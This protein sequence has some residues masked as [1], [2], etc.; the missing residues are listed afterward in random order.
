[1]KATKD[2]PGQWQNWYWICFAGAVLFIPATLLMK[3]RWSPKVAAADTAEHQRIIADE[4]V[5]LHAGG[6]HATM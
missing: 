1:M 3:G 4:L 6:S 2:A 5:A